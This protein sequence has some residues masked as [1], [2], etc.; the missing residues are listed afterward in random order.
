MM[1]ILLA[2]DGSGPAKRAL[3]TAADIAKG[4][5]ATLTVL[6]VLPASEGMPSADAGAPAL[7]S[8]SLE[9]AR[10]LLESRLP[11]CHFLE[12]TGD[13][14]TAIERL[15]SEGEFDLVVLGS[16]G[17]GTIARVLLGSTSEH[18]ATHAQ[19]SV[20]IVR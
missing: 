3:E 2:Y 19:T 11:A 20:L 1:K 17:L 18:V 8:G 16:R 9:E 14:A 7:H 12:S 4:T 6:T 15:A 5:A 13:A 10:M